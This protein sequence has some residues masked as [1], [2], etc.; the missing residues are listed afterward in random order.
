MRVK[1]FLTER[2]AE[3]WLKRNRKKIKMPGFVPSIQGNALV[4][5]PRRRRR[6]L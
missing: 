1:F 2:K 5:I 6:F 3:D 4:M